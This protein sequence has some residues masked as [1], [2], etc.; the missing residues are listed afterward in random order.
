MWGSEYLLG[1]VVPVRLA[2]TC[3]ENSA[4]AIDEAVRELLEIFLDR[5]DCGA[6]AVQLA[7]FTA[8]HDL[9]AAKPAAAARRAGWN[10]TQFLCL[11]EMVTDDDVPLCLRVLL[12]VWRGYGASPLKPVYLRGA[13]V[14]RPD[15]VSG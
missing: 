11:A 9:T 14:L 10:E 4:A 8:T 13:Q 3:R 7:I 1:P 12:F 6:P 5:N 15:L 2:T